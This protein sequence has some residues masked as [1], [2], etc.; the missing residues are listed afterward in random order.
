MN[1]VYQM[2]SNILYLKIYIRKGKIIDTCHYEC[3]RQTNQVDFL[4]FQQRL[5]Y[6]W[7]IQRA[8]L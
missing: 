1:I 2:G 7:Q 3:Q 6:L 5:P 4:M 8:V